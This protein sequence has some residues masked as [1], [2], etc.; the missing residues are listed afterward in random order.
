MAPFMID[1]TLSVWKIFTLI[2]SCV[3]LVIWTPVSSAAEL[4]RAVPIQVPAALPHEHSHRTQA[5]HV[6]MVWQRLQHEA[7]FWWAHE[8]THRW[9]MSSVV[10][11]D[12]MCRCLKL[13][14][15]QEPLVGRQRNEPFDCRTRLLV[16][17]PCSVPRSCPSPFRRS[18]S[19]DSS[20]RWPRSRRGGVSSTSWPGQIHRPGN[21]LSWNVVHV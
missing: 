20:S 10:S 7:V 19:P 1:L 8:N 16:V 12:R 18:C 6:P 3:C 14:W 2:R 9:E 13:R 15:P 21:G 11:S 4:W 5:V 17:K